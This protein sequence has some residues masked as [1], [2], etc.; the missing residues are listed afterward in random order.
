VKS[1]FLLMVVLVLLVTAGFAQAPDAGSNAGPDNVKGCLGGSDGNYTVAEDGTDQ[2]F[3][4][5]TSSV[6]LKSHLGHDVKLTG[7]KASGT[8]GSGAADNSFTVAEL[9]MI[10]EHCGAAS[11]TAAGSAATV[12]PSSETVS[13]P[14]ADATAPAT[15]TTPSSATA[16]T[17]AM[18]ASIPVETVSPPAATVSTPAA[19]VNPPAA[20][21]STPAATVSPSS[22]AVSAPAV[23]TSAT[24]AAVNPSAAT[25]SVPP[26]NVAH[27]TRLS[28]HPR[29]HSAR[30]AVADPPPAATVS[31]SSETVIPSA[32]DAATPAAT[33]TPSSDTVNPPAAAPAS[34]VTHRGWPLWLLISGVALVIALGTLVPVLGRWRKQKMLEQTGTENLSF[35]NE[36]SSDRDKPKPSKVA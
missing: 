11:A 26:A 12:S 6:D 32:A 15:T 10:S 25:V 17:S 33:A 28:A 13:P 20:T 4:I 18:D 16:G 36:T 23:D 14:P 8:A 30:Q 2:I 29:T 19:T 5:A 35:T 34:T 24:A 1:V 7:R 9:N 27:T 22:A 31:S 3:K 21:V